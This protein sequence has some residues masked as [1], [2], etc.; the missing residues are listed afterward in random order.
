MGPERG[1]EGGGAGRRWYCHYRPLLHLLRS[2]RG[3]VGVLPSMGAV[4]LVLLV[5]TTLAHH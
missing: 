3:P 4:R 1:P 5:L 2:R